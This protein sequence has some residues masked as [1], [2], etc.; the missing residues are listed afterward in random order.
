MIADELSLDRETLLHLK[1]ENK[2]KLATLNEYDLIG[3]EILIQI[4]EKKREIGDKDTTLHE[5]DD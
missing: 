5:L 4:E 1:V 2:K 3:D